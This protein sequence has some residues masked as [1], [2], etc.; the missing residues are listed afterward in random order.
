MLITLVGKIFLKGISAGSC[1][2]GTKPGYREPVVIVG[3]SDGSFPARDL[4]PKRVVF[5]ECGK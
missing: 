3:I 5:A 4:K 1:G 2:I